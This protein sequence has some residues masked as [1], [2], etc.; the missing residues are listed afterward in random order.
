MLNPVR[1]ALRLAAVI[2]LVVFGLFSVGLLF[3]LIPLKWRLWM[4]HRWSRCLL[5]CCGVRIVVQ[6]NPVLRESVFWVANHVS[7]VDIFVLNSVRTTS[8]VAKSDI[9]RW[10]VIGW[11]VAGAGTVFI[12]RGQ[13]QAIKAVG[14]QMKQRFE[15]GE[16]VGLFPEGTTSPG[17]DIADF[18]TSLF[19]PAIR[20]GVD[21]QPVAL[22][23]Y[24]RGVR[25]D[26]IAFVGEQT[27]VQ[28]IWC[29]LS[30]GKSLVEVEFLPLMA[31][32]QCREMG[33]AQVA[34]QAHQLIRAAVRQGLEDVSGTASEPA[35]H[36]PG[37]V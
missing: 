9:R 20:A 35:E 24:D 12:D 16:V 17:F 26:R 7:W 33:R 8:F 11:L 19:E 25:S 29:M 5:W 13:R 10:P 36:N 2:L 28:N 14:E 21:I 22:R 3:P 18:H 6:G 37:P 1:F 23:F 31:A 15:R 32:E 34:G 30:A 27:L 4:N